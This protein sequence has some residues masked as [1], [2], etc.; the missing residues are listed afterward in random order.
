MVFCFSLCTLLSFP[1]SG[2]AASPPE[3]LAP[4]EITGLSIHYSHMSTE[5][6]SS[7]D[8]RDD[9]GEILFSCNFF[10]VDGQEITLKDV[11]VDPEYMRRLR[12]TA[13]E[14]HFAQIQEQRPPSEI[15]I[16]D[17]PMSFMH[18][19]WPGGKRKSFNY[20]PTHEVE[21]L[22]REI[23]DA[24]VN[25]PGAPEEISA[26]YYTYTHTPRTKN[27]HFGLYHDEGNFLLFAQYYPEGATHAV[28]FE[29][30]P[31]DPAHMQRLREIIRAH[32]I[33]NMRGKALHHKELA[34]SYPYTMLNLYWPDMRFVQLGRPASGSEE[35]EAFFRNLI[36]EY[37]PK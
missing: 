35:L 34:F 19:E 33:A 15:F 27:F 12:E 8:L 22:F 4:E 10:T 11:P 30:V 6:E 31:V 20:W 18:I 25:K 36:Q 21:T 26:L 17:E 23:A 2:A 5:S 1:A 9:K 3:G 7:F 14:H 16:L 29:G 24:C 28:A 13:K 37:A 32:N